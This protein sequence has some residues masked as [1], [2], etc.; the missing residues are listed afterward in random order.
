MTRTVWLASYPKSGNT[1][2]RIFLANLLHPGSAQ[3]SLNALPTS[4]PIAS[5]RLYFDQP[6]GVPS[7]LL[8]EAELDRLRP[9]AAARLG[10]L[11]NTPLLVRKVHD[12]YRWLPDGQ[13]LLG[14][15]PGF[16]ALYLLRAPWDV[17]VSMTHHFG[18]DLDE[19]VRRLSDPEHCLAKPGE[20]L[21]SQLAQRLGSWESHVLGWLRA[22]LP[23]CLLRYEDLK[24]QPLGSFR[25]AVR[26][27]GLEHD[28]AAINA[29]LDASRIETLQRQEA[30]ERF[31]ETPRR[32]S[33]F[34][35][36]GEVGEGLERLS[37]RQ[38]APLE[39]MAARVAACIAEQH[40]AARAC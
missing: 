7:A 5:S 15:A 34:F 17:A 2:F 40:P 18:V 22:P 14:Q 25:R 39:A 4:T 16:S 38:R 21:H 29:A 9:A 30:H 23:V 6:L 10:A 3:V 11:W 19:A 24:A 20:A 1:W 31:T 32:A 37:P 8:T 27:L 35:R 12:A 26:F 13:P 28:D 36:R 33:R